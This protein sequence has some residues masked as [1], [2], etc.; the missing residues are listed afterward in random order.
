M[1]SSPLTATGW[2]E[3]FRTLDQYMKAF[4]AQQWPL[5]QD[6]SGSDVYV[7][8]HRLYGTF[9]VSTD[10]LLLDTSGVHSPRKQ[11][12]YAAAIR[13]DFSQGKPSDCRFHGVVPLAHAEAHAHKI[14]EV[15]GID[16][17]S[18]G[19][20]KDLSLSFLWDVPLCTH[21]VLYDPRMRVLEYCGEFARHLHFPSELLSFSR[22]RL[23][24][25]P[26]TASTQ[27]RH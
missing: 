23:T 20:L 16:S 24:T 4:A 2:E 18:L 21:I 25:P 14:K 27:I 17:Q 6:G 8:L 13:Y 7:S 15:L 22:R 26:N 1:S 11:E 5:Q 10:I 12:R 9:P 19:A 3:L